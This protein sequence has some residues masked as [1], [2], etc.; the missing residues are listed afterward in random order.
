MY[1]CWAMNA[2]NAASHEVWPGACL[3]KTFRRQRPCS[4]RVWSKAWTF[5]RIR[6]LGQN[7]ESAGRG[8]WRSERD[9]NGN[10][11]RSLAW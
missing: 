4:V 11:V 8:A 5:A 3:P 10:V 7:D 2:V 9:E 1:G 6:V